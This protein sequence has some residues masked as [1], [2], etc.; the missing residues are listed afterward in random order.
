[1]CSAHGLLAVHYVSTTGRDA[2]HVRDDT[3]LHSTDVLLPTRA[4]R[5]QT[6]GGWRREG[7]EERKG[8]RDVLDPRYAVTAIVVSRTYHP[9]THAHRKRP[10]STSCATDLQDRHFAGASVCND[11]KLM[12]RRRGTVVKESR[13]VVPLTRSSVMTLNYCSCPA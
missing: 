13:K 3:K 1:M 7:K 2:I 11:V 5:V 10:P 12:F 4:K 9:R 6:K 8:T